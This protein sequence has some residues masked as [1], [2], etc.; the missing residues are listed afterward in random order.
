MIELAHHHNL[1]V[2][3]GGFGETSL[4]VTAF[5]QLAPLADYCDMDAAL[6]MADDP[7]EGIIFQGSHFSLPSRPG[8]GV[9]KRL[10]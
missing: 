6:L 5:A 3:L 9:V 10:L 1:R 7:Y 4:S 8:L 2:M